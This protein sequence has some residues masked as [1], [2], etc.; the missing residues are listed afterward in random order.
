MQKQPGADTLTLTRKI[1][2]VLETIQPSLPADVTIERD[3]FQQANF[4]NLAIGNV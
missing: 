4:I 3:I 2:E 1:H